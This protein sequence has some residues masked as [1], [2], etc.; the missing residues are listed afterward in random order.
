MGM[1]VPISLR[2]PP[3]TPEDFE[4]RNDFAM[5]NIDLDLVDNFDEGLK[6]IS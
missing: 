5:V 2:Q 1:S 4:I 3:E 6:M